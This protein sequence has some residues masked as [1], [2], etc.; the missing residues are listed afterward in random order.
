MDFLFAVVFTFN[1]ISIVIM[2]CEARKRNKI[3]GFYDKDMNYTLDE[4]KN[5]K[6]TMR[7]LI[8]I[9][10]AGGILFWGLIIGLASSF[11][12]TD[13]QRLLN[14]FFISTTIAFLPSAM[15][16]LNIYQLKKNSEHPH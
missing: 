6:K 12:S 11:F 5:H 9:G 1:V 15:G 13:F 3:Y 10:A 8:F 16:L 2:G 7:I 14:G 4:L